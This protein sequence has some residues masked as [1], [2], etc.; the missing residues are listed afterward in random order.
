MSH[1]AW[2]SPV[3]LEQ[4]MA[5][6]D[7]HADVETGGLLVGY[8]GE[9]AVVVTAVVGPGPGAE[10]GARH[11]VPDAPWQA[12]RLAGAYYA[13]GRV[14]TY[15]G[16]WHTHPGGSALLSRQDKRTL[17]RIARHDPARQA[18]PVMAI[19]VPGEQPQFGI[20]SY[21]GQWRRPRPLKVRSL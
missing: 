9:G 7:V 14:H 12:A 21:Q 18:S 19:L 11:F 1:F 8:R 15:I 6:A 16:D 13:S 20:W 17:A 2:V 3:A 5:E 10:H 4:M